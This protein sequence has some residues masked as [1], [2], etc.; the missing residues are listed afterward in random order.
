MN[1]TNVPETVGYLFW[2]YLAGFLL[3]GFWVARLATRLA[4]L[5]K[6]LSRLDNKK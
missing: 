1:P 3:I 4:G 5:E 6:R 2:G